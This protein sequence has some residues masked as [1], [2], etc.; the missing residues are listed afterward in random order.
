[1]GALVC[2]STLLSSPSARAADTNPSVPDPA[3]S[4]LF[5]SGRALLDDGRWE[6][7]CAKFEASM[8]LY[9]AA[10]TLLN[11]ARCYEH[12]GKIALAWSAYQR[13]L[14][15]NRE[16]QGE[17]RKKALEEIAKKGLAGV[18]PRLPRIRLA[19]EGVPAGLRVTHNGQDVPTAMLSTVIPVDPGPQSISAEAPGY[20]PF[21]RT[22]DVDEGEIEEVAIKL[23]RVEEGSRDV[24]VV[25]GPRIPTWAWVAGAGGIALLAGSAVF[26]IDQAY[27]E[28]R[29]LGW[30]R[31]DLEGGCPVVS[32]RYDIEADNARKNRDFALFASLGGAGVVALGAAIVG[33]VTAPPPKATDKPS[34]MI[35]PWIGP[36]RLGGGIGGRF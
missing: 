16:T 7:G 25:G 14:V 10:S 3:A 36:G 4:A 34:A 11:I 21:Q 22:V 35:T 1:M 31:G 6:E 12:K 23:E 30:C 9:P 20:M 5:Q 13:A 28:G 24:V 19:L 15:L 2:A 27:V 33:I 32:T 8:I 18:E 29:Q 26:R 17:E